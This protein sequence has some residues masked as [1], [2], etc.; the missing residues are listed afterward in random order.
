VSISVLVD[1][2]EI[3]CLL[4]EICIIFFTGR[5]GTAVSLVTQFDIKLVHAI[6]AEIS[7]LECMGF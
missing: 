1:I 6:E 2:L 4:Y 3:F 5:G 7:K